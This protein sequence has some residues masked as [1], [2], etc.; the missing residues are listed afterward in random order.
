MKSG[1]FNECFRL[2]FIAF[3]FG[4]RQV[5]LYRLYFAAFE[6]VLSVLLRVFP[7]ASL[8]MTRLVLSNFELL[9]RYRRNLSLWKRYE[10]AFSASV[11]KTSLWFCF[12]SSELHTFPDNF[13]RPYS[14]II[15]DCVAANKSLYFCQ[16]GIHL[17]RTGTVRNIGLQNVYEN[18]LVGALWRQYV[19]MWYPSD[20]VFWAILAGLSFLHALLV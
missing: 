19:F 2:I 15:V 20:N 17:S 13:L 5:A 14:W 9:W 8:I 11:P 4:V 7:N 12:Y 1:L 10:G 3:S 6:Q 18:Q 16:S